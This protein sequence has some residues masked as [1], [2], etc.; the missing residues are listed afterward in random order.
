MTAD[1]VGHGAQYQSGCL[2]AEQFRKG[3]GW[4]ENGREQKV[5][6]RH[7]LTPEVQKHTHT[8]TQPSKKGEYGAPNDVHLYLTVLVIQ[9]GD[10]RLV[11]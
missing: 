11:K 4:E 6:K 5:D 2:V 8:Q 9:V 7:F 3:I 10:Q 1:I